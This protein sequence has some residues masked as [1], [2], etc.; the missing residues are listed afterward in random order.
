M[1]FGV[2]L[3]R[4]IHGKDHDN[5]STTNNN[6]SIGHLEALQKLTSFETMSGSALSVSLALSGILP[7]LVHHR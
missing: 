5:T 1:L 3:F 6:F 4:K 7:V 2:V